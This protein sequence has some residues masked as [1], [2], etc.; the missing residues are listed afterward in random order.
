MPTVG[1]FW[2]FILGIVVS[3]L[4]NILTG[5]F[6]R[7]RGLR[8]IP[9]MMLYVAIHGSYVLLEMNR[10]FMIGQARRFPGWQSY[11]VVAAVAA[12]LA[13]LYWKAVNAAVAVLDKATSHHAA[14]AKNKSDL[15]DQQLCR[16]VDDVAARLRDIE[17]RYR[18]LS[19]EIEEKERLAM[20]KAKS[21]STRN[22]L[23]EESSTGMM[24]RHADETA[25]AR[26]LLG[27]VLFLRDELSL[28]LPGEKE[29]IEKESHQ[30]FFDGMLAGP[31]PLSDAAAFLERFA[32]KLCT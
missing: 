32:R 7:E 28:R 15:T 1:L 24:R 5:L 14:L 16:R 17:Q 4:V 10:D 3:A 31:S 9:W 22:R 13:V 30:P 27:E 8:L 19:V 26:R 12:I 11:L 25:E 18:V 6:N 2:G 23:W 20:M 21:E 29:H